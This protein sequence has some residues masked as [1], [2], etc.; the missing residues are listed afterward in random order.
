MKAFEELRATDPDPKLPSFSVGM[1][2][3]VHFQGCHGFHILKL[4][5]DS[6]QSTDLKNSAPARALD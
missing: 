6:C 3:F 2:W 4:I 1:E 5:S